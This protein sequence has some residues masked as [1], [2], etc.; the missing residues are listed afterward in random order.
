MIK[1]FKTQIIMVF[2]FMNSGYFKILAIALCNAVTA[3]LMYM[4]KMKNKQTNKMFLINRKLSKIDIFQ[5]FYYYFSNS[6]LKI[7]T[8]IQSKN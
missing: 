5:T 2:L 4:F 8:K 7:C 1:G 6:K 3:L